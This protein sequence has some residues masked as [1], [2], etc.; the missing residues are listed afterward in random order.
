MTNLH[1]I[2]IISHDLV[3]VLR[4]SAELLN[5]GLNPSVVLSD[6]NTS[7]PD[8]L[9]TISGGKLLSPVKAYHMTRKA[10]ARYPE[11]FIYLY[12][13]AFLRGNISSDIKALVDERNPEKIVF[14]TAR[15]RLR[16]YIRNGIAYIDDVPVN[17][18]LLGKDPFE[19]VKESYI[20]NIVREYSGLASKSIGL[21]DIERGSEHL[22][23][24]IASAK[25]S[26]VI[27]DAT[28]PHHLETIS[29]AIL[30]GD[31]RWMICGGGGLIKSFP[32]A[33]GYSERRAKLTPS[34]N[35]LPLIICVGSLDEV[36]ALQ[37]SV[38]SEK[39]FIYPVMVE[40]SELWDL[41]VRR[42]KITELVAEIGSHI[43]KGHNVAITTSLSR[44]V[45]R[46][47]KLAAVILAT[48]VRKT[49]EKH[50]IGGILTMGADTA[51][52]L[53]NELKVKNINVEGCIQEG[54]STIIAKAKTETGKTFILG[55][56]G[57]AVGDPL[58]IVRA[59]KFMRSG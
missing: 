29:R 41:Q 50:D 21:V 57:G 23:G 31:G 43:E 56:K 48:V 6:E 38:A 44:Y 54:V 20:P 40:P 49:M 46:V 17:H 2:A 3:A 26:V 35:E 19:P 51:N 45:S 59:I 22:G 7:I 30:H 11:H 53:C 16:R 15:P 34:T 27:C 18:T 10:I 42:E 32:V 39:A 14:C 55:T 24:I 47:R 28:K 5:F 58:E 52:I 1:K 4:V 37:L 8:I 9:T 36:S 13:D 33:L 12:E 25:E